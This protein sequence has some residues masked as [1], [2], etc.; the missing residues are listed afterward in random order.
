MNPL[1]KSSD[2]NQEKPKKSRSRNRSIE[3]RMKDQE[4]QLTDQTSEQ[5]RKRHA[6][7]DVYGAIGF[8]LMY[9]D[10]ICQVEDGLFSQTIS[11]D[12][13]SYQSAREE[14]KKAVFS[15][16]CQLFDYFGAESCVQLTVVNTLIP[17]SEIGRRCSSPPMTPTP[18][19][20]HGN[21][22]ASSTTR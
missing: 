19:V 11:F 13:I 2:D 20:T 1:K 15:G 8:D 4:K 9:K 21:T 5:R 3:R 22:T 12:D 10:G 16:W 14:N 18:L 6:A 7:K 17:Q